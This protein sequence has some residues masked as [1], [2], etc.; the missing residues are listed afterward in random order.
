MSLPIEVSF[1]VDGEPALYSGPGRD[2]LLRLTNT[3]GSSIRL[4][5]LAGP[6]SPTS[7]HLA[8]H[9]P[10]GTLSPTSLVELRAIEGWSAAV[11]R[12]G[13]GAGGNLWDVVF[14]AS[15]DAV[16]VPPAGQ[17]VVQLHGV[18]AATGGGARHTRAV[19][20]YAVDTV[21]TG[22]AAT[23]GL[24]GSRSVLLYVVPWQ[25]SPSHL[26]LMA[27]VMAGGEVI[28]RSEVVNELEIRITPDA[29]LGAVDLVGG[30][31]ALQLSWDV[32][33]ADARWWA[34]CTPAQANAMTVELAWSVPGE[35][36][37]APAPILDEDVWV[38][39]TAA[40]WGVTL[41]ESVALQEGDHVSLI[42]RNLY[43]AHPSGP[44]NLYLSVVGVG[45]GVG[46]AVSGSFVLPVS[47][48][49]YR[50]LG[51]GGLS[52]FA[53]AGETLFEVRDESR[54]K[55]A[56]ISRSGRGFA[57]NLF[58]DEVTAFGDEIIGATI[59]S[60][61]D[62]SL[63]RSLAIGG[64]LRL[65]GTIELGASADQFTMGIADDNGPRGK[66]RVALPSADRD[67]VVG[68][69]DGELVFG[70]AL[71]VRDGLRVGG[72]RPIEVFEGTVDVNV[73]QNTGKDSEWR[74]VLLDGPSI[75]ASS[76]QA[77]FVVP[78]VAVEEEGWWVLRAD[79]AVLKRWAAVPDPAFG[80]ISIVLQGSTRV[81]VLFIRRELIGP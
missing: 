25:H 24:R 37:A 73:P 39:P 35:D 5:G 78:V 59:T 76:G 33:D 46:G 4:A 10:A 2:A 41:P 30:Q 44:A 48:Q 57:L 19:V 54:R 6:P 63:F 65:G 29:V 49:S 66:L 45:D 64:S 17:I 12:D 52:V 43:T 34:L 31:T 23:T 56:A 8:L 9:I 53:G 50:W 81:T 75:R 36:R 1:T 18:A 15:R 79:P 71:D 62:A 67:Y 80:T 42:V 74:A 69:G 51:E 72:H 16:T 7:H 60:D 55:A 38:S 13:R 21:D 27:G 14:L 11:E 68:V 20:D 3:S 61:G 47:K 22:T 70:G 77:E 28:N 26:H 58:R 40:T 32:G